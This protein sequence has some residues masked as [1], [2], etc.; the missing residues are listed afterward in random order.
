MNANLHEGS[1]VTTPMAILPEEYQLIVE[2][3]IP[4]FEMHKVM[5]GRL[6]AKDLGYFNVRVKDSF[7]GG[8]AR[9]S[10]RWF[11]W[12]NAYITYSHIGKG[13]RVAFCPDDINERHEYHHWHN[14][15][16]LAGAIHSGQFR[17]VRYHTLQGVTSEGRITEEILFLSRLIHD[18]KAIDKTNGDVFRSNDREKVIQFTMERQKDEHE[19]TEVIF[20]KI[21]PIEKLIKLH[22]RSPGGWIMSPEFQTELLPDIKK[23]VTEKFKP[24]QVAPDVGGQIQEYFKNMTPEQRRQFIEGENLSVAG[25]QNPESVDGKK[26]EDL[27]INDLRRIAAGMKILSTN[28]T[29][30]ELIKEIKISSKGRAASIEDVVG[31]ETEEEKNI[32]EAA[33]KK[34]RD[35]KAGRETVEL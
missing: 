4:L 29:R 26:L 22:R 16:M 7:F 19:T 10:V 13:R 2:D 27:K 30:D 6:D 1:L 32:R 9:R 8:S 34:D 15:I 5:E 11:A 23:A 21:E 18:W 24:K 33:L 28:K 31:P 35:D 3:G 17:I 12:K 14:R 25:P 20:S